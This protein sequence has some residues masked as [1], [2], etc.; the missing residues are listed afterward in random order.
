MI[1]QFE[2]PGR[3]HAPHITDLDALIKLDEMGEE[4]MPSQGQV[5]KGEK[6]QRALEEKPHVL[7]CARCHDLKYKRK[8]L[9]L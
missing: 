7:I 4:L 8:L 3:D 2:N 9:D 5:L 1:R 6:S